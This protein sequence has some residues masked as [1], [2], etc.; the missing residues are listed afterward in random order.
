MSLV[1]LPSVGVKYIVFDAQNQELPLTFLFSLK[2][3]ETKKNASKAIAFAQLCLLHLGEG[4]Q[5]KDLSALER[6]L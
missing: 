6:E 5:S 4:G 3:E 2:T 1:S